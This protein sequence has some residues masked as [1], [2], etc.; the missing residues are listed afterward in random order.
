MSLAHKSTELPLNHAAQAD[1]SASQKRRASQ[2]YTAR[3]HV[4]DICNVLVASMNQPCPGS[5]Y[6]V[7]DDNPASRTEV[8][9][10]ASKLLQ[11]GSD[12]EAIGTGHAQQNTTEVDSSTASDASTISSDLDQHDTA[13]TD[14]DT[15][16]MADG[17]STDSTLHNI[18]KTVAAASPDVKTGKQAEKRVRNDKMKSALHVTL[19]FPTYVEGLSAIHKGDSRPFS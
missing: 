18:S 4:Q 9:A 8:M 13:G 6:N 17:S 15:A 3:C 7:V 1:A 11:T 2:Q 5:L 10:F 19:E 16:S 14:S 12:A